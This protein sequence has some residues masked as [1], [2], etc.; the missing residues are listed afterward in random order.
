MRCYYRLIN[1][2][3]FG[4]EIGDLNLKLYFCHRMSGLLKIL[5]VDDEQPV[6][7]ALS[8]LVAAFCENVEVVGEASGTQAGIDAIRKLQPDVVLLDIDLQDGTGFDVIRHFQPLHFKVIFITTYQEYALQAFRFS[9]VDYLL[10]PADPDLLAEAIR[11][12]RTL[13][14]HEQTDRKLHTLM[15]NLEQ[16][17]GQHRKIVLNTQEAMHVV[18]VGDIV[19]LEA[20]RNYTRFFILHQKP[21]LV[22]GSLID[23]EEMLHSSGFFRSHHSHLVNLSFVERYEKR[24][25]GRLVMK[26]GSEALVSVRRKDELVTALN[27]I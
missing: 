14:G 27:R 8:G 26:D 11:K 2:G 7:E 25:G 22:S 24:D 5:I 16:V 20:D 9:A 23:Y 3:R 19:K 4:S 1:P 13:I 17:S 6:R 18:P 12:A 21:L 10:K 15:H